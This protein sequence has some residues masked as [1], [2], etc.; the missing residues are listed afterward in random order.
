[1]ALCNV[2]LPAHVV[3]VQQVREIRPGVVRRLSLGGGTC[4]KLVWILKGVGAAHRVTRLGAS[5]GPLADHEEVLWQRP[6][7]IRFEHAVLKD[8]AGGVGPV[9]GDIPGVL[10]AHDVRP[11]WPPPTCGRAGSRSPRWA[12]LPPP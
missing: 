8:E 10:V 5:G 6:R 11:G 4:P 2:V 9:V 3:L 7:G 1:R 12:Q